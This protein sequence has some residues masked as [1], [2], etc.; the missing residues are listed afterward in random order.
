MY[1]LCLPLVSVHFSW[2]FTLNG[3]GRLHY[4][5]WISSNWLIALDFYVTFLF[6]LYPHFLPLYIYFHIFFFLFFF[7]HFLS[8]IR[9]PFVNII[10]AYFTILSTFNFI[11][12]DI[13]FLF[14]AAIVFSFPID[15]I[16]K[17]EWCGY[18]CLPCSTRNAWIQDT[19]SILQTTRSVFMGNNYYTFSLESLWI[20]TTIS[21]V[22]LLCPQCWINLYIFT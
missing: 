16:P 3:D 9:L 6:K 11:H 20:Y 19:D 17:M 7:S 13:S 2:W 1:S 12:I 10:F 5:V 22:W 15:F 4:F 21:S 8:L 14:R 18:I